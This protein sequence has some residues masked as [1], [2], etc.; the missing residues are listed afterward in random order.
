ME[1]GSVTALTSANALVRNDST[2]KLVYRYTSS[3]RRPAINENSKGRQTTCSYIGMLHLLGAL[4]LAKTLH[5]QRRETTTSILPRCTY[6]HG[7]SGTTLKNIALEF[8]VT[9]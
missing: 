4:G 2:D 9:Q 6:E 8:D 1:L 7:T 3:S 5:P